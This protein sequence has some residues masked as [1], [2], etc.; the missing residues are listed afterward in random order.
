M[1]NV[2]LISKTKQEVYQQLNQLQPLKIGFYRHQ[3]TGRVRFCL[4]LETDVNNFD[5]I[6]LVEMRISSALRYLRT[7]DKTNAMYYNVAKTS[8]LDWYLQANFIGNH[9]K[10]KS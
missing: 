6:Y 5:K 7:G 8:A 4:G 1:A 2:K 3:V 10:Q 9:Y